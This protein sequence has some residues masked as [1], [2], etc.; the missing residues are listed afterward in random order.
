MA[1]TLEQKR[2]L[3]E[4]DNKEISVAR[5]CQ[6][7]GLSRSS[8]YFKPVAVSADNLNLMELIDRQYTTTPYYGSRKMAAH[9]KKATHKPVNRKHVQRLMQLMGICAIYPKPDLSKKSKSHK[10]YPYLLRDYKITAPN[11][12]WSTDITYMKLSGGFAYLTAVIDW[13]SRYV[14]SWELSNTMDNAFCISALTA[15][16]KLGSPIIFNTDQGSQ[17]TSLDFT[18]VLL[19]SGIKISMDGRGRCLDNIFV[20]RL[21]RSVK[22]EDIFIK[23]Y[24]T[25]PDANR[26]LED[27]FYRY[28]NERPHQSLGY[29]TPTEVHY[30]QAV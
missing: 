29:K 16:L 24:E 22:Y 21:W 1:W 10:I 3:I 13:Y 15:A 8:Y 17:Y 4:P 23:G 7:L 26:G 6:L 11:Q 27:Y 20:E 19:D 25:L 28:N 12:V 2:L 30:A 14:L 9:L 5:Q 18:S